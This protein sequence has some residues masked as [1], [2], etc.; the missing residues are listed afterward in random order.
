MLQAI[1]IYEKEYKQMFEHIA[2]EKFL[3]QSLITE[4]WSFIFEK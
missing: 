4:C 1:Y 2:L 3:I